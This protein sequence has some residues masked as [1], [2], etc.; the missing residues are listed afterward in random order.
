MTLQDNAYSAFMLDYAAGAL[1]PAERVAAEL[2][3]A[4]S[5]EGRRNARLF[6]MV[7]GA[8]MELGPAGE[9]GAAPDPEIVRPRVG[10]TAARLDP[11]L[12][13]DLLSLPWRRNVFGVQ[14]LPAGLPMA[15]LLRLDPGERAPAHGHGRRDVTV[16]LCG[17]FADDFGVYERGDLAFAEPG[18][19]HEPR[20]VGERPCGCFIATEPG[21]PLS[22][23]LGAIGLGRGPGELN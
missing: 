14:S 2:H 19:K 13:R 6:E 9:P 4:L 22:G 17:A 1:S 15:S 18:M 10:A 5:R 11:F 16:V 12:R 8:L 3:C 20:A 7:G 21:R 23:L